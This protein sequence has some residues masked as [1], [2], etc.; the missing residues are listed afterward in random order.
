MDH[1]PIWADIGH[2]GLLSFTTARPEPGVAIVAMR[3]E[4]DL[5]TAPL[6]ADEFDAVR[7]TRPKSLVVNMSGVVFLS[8]TGI[9]TLLDLYDECRRDGTDLVVVASPLVRRVLTVM[10]LTELPAVGGQPSAEADRR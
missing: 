1:S 10:G 6:M 3:G 7:R 2:H 9:G 4:L 5:A 8:S